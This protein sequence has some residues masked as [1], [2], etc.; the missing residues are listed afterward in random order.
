MAR[1]DFDAKRAYEL[2]HITNLQDAQNVEWQQAGLMAGKNVHKK[3]L[4]VSNEQGPWRFNRW[5]ADK[6]KEAG[7]I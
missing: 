4:F 2:W 6:L 3:S 7:A 1:E 5:V